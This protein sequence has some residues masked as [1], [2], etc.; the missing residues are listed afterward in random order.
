M[1]RKEFIPLL[2]AC[3]AF[4]GGC[5]VGP[6][7]HRPDAPTPA[8]WKTEAPWRSSEPSDQIPKGAWWGAFG[9]D[10]LNNLET[11]AMAANQD[12]AGAVA[13]LEQARAQ[14]R[15][16]VSSLYPQVGA[17]PGIARERESANRPFNPGPFTPISNSVFQIPFTVSWEPDLFGRIRRTIASANASYQA[18]GADLA[19]VQLT[20]AAELAGDYFNA[21]QLDS[22]IAVLDRSVSAFE[23]G[24]QLVESRQKGGVASGLD[25]AQELT[26]LD[27][28]RTQA[29]LLRQ[30]RA[31]FE[32][33]IAVL[34]GKP[35]S[36]Y[37]LPNAEIS[38]TPPAV[39]LGMPSD[40]LERRPDVA[41]SE[42]QM[43]AASEQIGI[44]QTAYYPSFPMSAGIGT[45]STGI[46]QI[47]NGAST[48]WSVGVSAVESIFT[49]GAR[50]AQVQFEQAGYQNTV[51]GYRGTVLNAF[52]EV[53]DNLASLSVLD[54][55][56]KTQANAVEDARRALDIATNRY[57][58][59][60]VSYLDVITAQQT[61]LQNEQLAATIQ[62][63]RLV[64]SVMLIKALGGGWD[65]QSIAAL[66]IKPS[67]KQ[68]VEP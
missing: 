3:V 36:D 21:R 10:E 40:L 6:N 66:K 14:A 33:A 23:K 11:Q 29:I 39:P 4:L 59:G 9:N 41:E 25:V 38:S 62:G 45:Q 47:A 17:Q 63:E 52:R 2:A 27:T 13:R 35:A 30:Q 48:F 64:S 43:A 15:I 16:A 24:L 67:I 26:L 58:G 60:L 54:Q 5:M 49:G 22:E 61:L 68:A 31:Q 56:Q 53:E 55:A 7:Y 37:S 1:S 34:I 12:I 18:S 19:N 51:A 8:T 46:A 57:T 20:V 50:R 65:A 32:D 44:A 42:R 28:T